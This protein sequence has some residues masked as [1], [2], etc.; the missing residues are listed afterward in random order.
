MN[1]VMVTDSFIMR[2]TMMILEIIKW[3]FGAKPKL[4]VHGVKTIDFK[5]SKR[6]AQKDHLE[7]DWM[8]Y[9]CKRKEKLKG[10]RDI[11]HDDAPIHL[12]NNFFELPV[13]VSEKV[14]GDVVRTQRYVP[15]PAA[16]L[17]YTPSQALLLHVAVF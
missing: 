12:P 4:A 2:K 17:G 5:F 11:R 13:K 10:V 15:A 16:S 14:K 6:S 1:I 3:V 8:I 7:R 9:Q